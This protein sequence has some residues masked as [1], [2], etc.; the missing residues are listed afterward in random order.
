[1]ASR[2]QLGVLQIAAQECISGRFADT[3]LY[4]KG[5]K[6]AFK[7]RAV[8]ADGPRNGTC[9]ADYDVRMQ[10]D[11]GKYLPPELRQVTIDDRGRDQSCIDH[12]ENVFVFEILVRQYHLHRR[13]ALRGEP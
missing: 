9:G 3:V 8:L 7:L 12:L 6:H 2:A 11:V 1:V 5:I 4:D 10:R 13:F